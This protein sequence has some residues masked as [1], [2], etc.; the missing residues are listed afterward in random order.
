[1][2]DALRRITS[3]GDISRMKA[4]PRGRFFLRGAALRRARRASED[5]ALHG[6]GSHAISSFPC[7][8]RGS[9]DEIACPRAACLAPKKSMPSLTWRF[10]TTSA[11]SRGSSMLS[12]KNCQNACTNERDS[13][14]G[15]AK[16]IRC[17]VRGL[18]AGGESVE[19][20]L[21]ARDRGRSIVSKKIRYR[22]LKRLVFV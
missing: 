19:A 14:D 10:E 21:H 12:R 4:T 5:V 22:T 6:E 7:T 8:A 9:I 1:M 20:C 17:R 11:G 13:M 2:P 15:R 3:S 18:V 16:R